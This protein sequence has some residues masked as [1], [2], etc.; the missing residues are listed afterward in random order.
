MEKAREL[1]TLYPGRTEA[2][3]L[4]LFCSD[5]KFNLSL[6]LSYAGKIGCQLSKKMIIF[7]LRLMTQSATT[8]TNVIIAVSPLR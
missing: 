1:N 5:V 7:L 8:V 6:Y 4:P 3:L 2:W